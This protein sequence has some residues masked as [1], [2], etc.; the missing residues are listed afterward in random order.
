M[1]RPFLSGLNNMTMIHMKKQQ[2]KVSLS[3]TT[4]MI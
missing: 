4:R 2:L 3:I 1:I